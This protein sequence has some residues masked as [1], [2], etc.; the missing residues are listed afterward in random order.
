MEQIKDI[1]QRVQSLA[2]ILASPARD[3]DSE[4]KARREALRE[5]V[6]H[7]QWETVVL[8]IRIR[9]IRR[10]LAGIIAKLGPLSEHGVLRFLKNVDHA[11]TLN[12]FVQDLAYAV[13]DYQVRVKN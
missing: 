5:L 4:E 12:G 10:K 9:I 7:P 2:K 6:L 1:E 8:L 3:Q 13:T 11:N